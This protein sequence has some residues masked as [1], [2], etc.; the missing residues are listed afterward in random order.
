MDSSIIELRNNAIN[1][2]N[3]SKMLKTAFAIS[4]ILKLD[5][6]SELIHS[7]LYGYENYSK[8]PD[9]RKIAGQISYKNSYGTYDPIIF[10]SNIHNILE[11][12]K[13]NQPASQI[14]ELYN[15]PHEKNSHIII[16]FPQ[17]QVELIYKEYPDAKKVL[18][19]LIVDSSELKKVLENIKTMNFRRRII[20]FKRRKENCN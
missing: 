4:K 10:P 15:K 1:D 7:E 3:L 9:Y 19:V 14:E 6:F 8:I 18:P 12:R 17:K 2:E 20:I 16:N 5:D 13:L 11:T